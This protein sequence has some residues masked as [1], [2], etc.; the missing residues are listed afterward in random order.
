MLAGLAAVDYVVIFDQD[1]PHAVLR[2]IQPDVLVKGGTYREDEIVGREVVQE[3]GGRVKALG[4][5]PGVS[6]TDIVRRLRDTPVMPL[7]KAG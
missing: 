6:T 5:T 4:V 3:Y 2:H 1:T 7:R